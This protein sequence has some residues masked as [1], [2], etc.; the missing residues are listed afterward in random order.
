MSEL[1]R[2]R[3]WS[4]MNDHQHLSTYVEGDEA[5]F[6][7]LVKKYFRMVYTVAARQTGDSH[8]AEDI[9]Q[10][11]FLILSRKARGLSTRTSVP[12]WLLRTTR[13]VCRDALKMRYRREQN[14]RNLAMN[15]EPQIQTK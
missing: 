6:E 1:A 14:E 11:V 13:F 12:G 15:L 8:L 4:F 7:A 5:A 2:T 9:A 10:S 3:S